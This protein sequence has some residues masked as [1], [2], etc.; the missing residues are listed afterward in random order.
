MKK[1]RTELKAER[2]KECMV[3]KCKA[4]CVTCT[5]NTQE[6]I[7]SVILDE[8]HTTQMWCFSACFMPEQQKNATYY[9]CSVTLYAL[10][11]MTW[12]CFCF[13]YTDQNVS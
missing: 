6:S 13:F 1:N 3:A 11:Y 2:W 8:S 12:F 5:V 9:Q 10:E 4:T 7:Q